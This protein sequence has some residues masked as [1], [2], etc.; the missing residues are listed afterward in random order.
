LPARLRQLVNPH[1]VDFAA[2]GKT[3][4]GVVG[5]GHEQPVDEVFLFHGGG[6]FALATAPLCGV[7]IQRLPLDVAGVRERYDNVLGRNQIFGIKA[8]VVVNNLGT[9]IARVLGLDLDQLASHHFP[10]SVGIVQYFQK[11]AD[12]FQHRIVF[13]G[14]LVLLQAGKAMQPEVEDRLGLLLAEAVSR[15]AEAELRGKAFGAGGLSA[16]TAE[17]LG[18]HARRPGPARQCLLRVGRRGRRLNGLDDLVDTDQRNG[19]TFENMGA[20]ARLAELVDRAPRYHLAAVAHER[21]DHLLEVEQPG[22]PVHQRHQVDAEYRLQ[23]GVLVDVVQHDF[24]ILATLEFDDHAHAV[25]VGLVAKLADAVQPLLFDELGNFFQQSRL[26]DLKG[27]LGDDDAL[28]IPVISALEVGAGANVDA[29]AATGV[30]LAD[31]LGTIDDCGGGKIRPGDK[32]HQTRN[33]DGGVVDVSDASVDHFAEIV[34]RNVRGHAYGDTRRT[35]DQQIGETG[36]KY[37][38]FFLGFVVSR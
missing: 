24:R 14:D 5:V 19:E 15:V 21:F 3:Q 29:A 2:I 8:P 9:A 1:P 27:Q 10:E 37:A 33:V 13:L 36:R 18:D 26:V 11:F 20:A 12:L 31:P 23:R 4:N 32:L 35:V 7:R 16:R 34:R 30:S 17:H 25:F 6:G 28:A 38:G 22:L